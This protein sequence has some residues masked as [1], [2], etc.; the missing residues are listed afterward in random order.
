MPH[1]NRRHLKLPPAQFE[2]LDN[3]LRD[4]PPLI[5]R[6]SLPQSLDRRSGQGKADR[7]RG[8][9]FLLRYRKRG[10]AI[11]SVILIIP[12][13][14]LSLNA[15]SFVPLLQVQTKFFFAVKVLPSCSIRSSPSVI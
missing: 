2:M 1:N 12:T 11:R 14:L 9:S 7:T 4:R 15:C 6:Q 13:A 8:R 3:R 10:Y 5:L